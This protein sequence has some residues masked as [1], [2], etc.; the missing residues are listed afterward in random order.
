MRRFNKKAKA[1]FVASS[2]MATSLIGGV[3]T[4]LVDVFANTQTDSSYV[5][6][7]SPLD[8]VELSSSDNTHLGVSVQDNAKTESGK[9]LVLDYTPGH[10]GPIS[11]TIPMTIEKTADDFEGL[12]MW[13]DVPETADEYSFTMYVVKNPAIW[14]DMQMASPLT[15]IS[16]DGTITEK[17]SVWKRQ[18]LNGFTG[19]VM[20]P[21]MTYS[22]PAPVAGQMY[23]I[24][25]MMETEAAENASRTEAMEMTI[26]SFGYYNDTTSFLFE[27][28]G[29]EAMAKQTVKE[30]DGYIKD[31]DELKPRNDKQKKLR[32]EMLVHF[33]NLKENFATLSEA[34]AVETAKG[35]YD[36][37]YAR[38]EEYLYGDIRQTEFIMSFAMMADTHFTTSWIN[39]NF[40]NA[41]NDAKTLDPDLSAAFILGD[42]SNEGVS[43][44]DDKYTDLDNY[45]D[46]LDSYVYQNSK[47]EKIP[48]INVMGNHDVRGPSTENY[49]SGAYA[50][51]VEMYLQREPLAKAAN[52]IQF[53]TWINGYHFV[54]LNTDEYHSDYCILSAETID[55]LDETL[56]ENE[57]GKPIFVMMHQNV[58]HVQTKSD[59]KM[60]F[61]EVIARHPTAIVSSGHAHAE[62]GVGKIVQEGDGVYVNQPAMVKAATQYYFAEVYEGGVIFRAREAATKSWVISSDVTVSNDDRSSNQL[63]S[64]DTFDS[65][66][67]TTT[68][69]T[70]SIVKADNVSGKAL[71]LVG[72]TA[73]ENVSVPVYAMGNIDNYAGYGVYI[74][75]ETAVQLAVDGVGLKANATYYNVVNGTL[76]EKTTGAN[77]EIEANG[78]VVLP[79]E[80]FDGD[81]APSK[82][83]TL[84][85]SVGDTQTVYLDKVCYYF[86]ANDFTAANSTLSYV[87]YNEDG[88]VVASGTA[89]FGSNLNVPE[90]PAKAATQ[91]ET[92]TFVGWDMDGDKVVDELPETLKGNFSATAV[93]TSTARQYTYTFLAADGVEVLETATVD[94]GTAITAPTVDKL[95]GWDLDEDGAIESLP[96]TLTEGFAAVAIIGEPAYEN[97]EI[98]F[99]PSLLSSIEI[100]TFS[101][102]SAVN[103]CTVNT[104]PVANANAPS[105][106]VVQY[107]YNY[108]DGTK[109]QNG[110]NYIDMQMPYL[111]DVTN[112]QGYAIWVEV[113]ATTEGYI[114]GLKFNGDNRLSGTF[115]NGWTLIDAQ[116]NQT[117][118]NATWAGASD[119]PRIGTGFTG[120]VIADK[121]IYAG[122]VIAPNAEGKIRFQIAETGRTTP[123]T[124]SIGQVLM[125]SDKAAII[126]ELSDVNREK[127]LEYS[128]NDGNGHIY[129]AGQ[130]PAGENDTTAI[131]VPE[132]PVHSNP[133]V[134]FAGW[135]TNQDGYPDALPENGLITKDLNA[136]AIFYHVDA[137]TTIDD[138]TGARWSKENTGGTFTAVEHADSPSG[139]AMK[140]TLS[141]ASDTV[142]Y[143]KLSL[144]IDKQPTGFAV[145]MDSSSMN[146]FDMRLWKNWVNKSHIN[147]DG[148]YIYFYGDNGSLYTE[149]A[150]RDLAVPA[151][152]KGWVIIPM[153]AFRDN[154][155]LYNGDYFR[156]GFPFNDGGN[157]NLSGDVYFG[158]AVRFNCTV[159]MFLKQ[160]DKQVY[161]FK[162]Y[163]GSFIKTVLMEDGDTFSAPADPTRTDWT[164][165]GWDI[166]GD[167]KEDTLPTTIGRSFV[168]TAV[169]T[170]TFT[171]KFVD[172]QNNVILEKTAEY[173]TLIL[174]PFRYLENDPYY[175]YTVDYGTWEAGMLLTQDYT[176]VVTSERTAK[177]FTYT[178]M[179]GTEIV[180][181]GKLTYGETITLP[182]APT[183]D[184]DAQY[185]YT[186]KGWTGYTD[187]MT[188]AGDV[189]FTAEYTT[190]TN[191]YDVVF[192]DEDGT[193]V[194]SS[195]EVEYGA[196]ITLP[197]EPTKAGYTFKGWT[198][199]TDGMTV[200]QDVSFTAIFEENEPDQDSSS[201]SSSGDSSS[202]SSEDSSDSSVDS[203]DNSSD[204]SSSNGGQGGANAWGCNGCG[205]NL[206]GSMTMVALF[207]MIGAWIAIR[208]AKKGRKE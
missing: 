62:F 3:A 20:M 68:N 18:Q 163:D 134:F 99:D 94:Y 75:S 52:S 160:I 9:G 190:T 23:Q 113:A 135:D 166:D 63:F 144:P 45:Y 194:L 92:F 207:A 187:G 48:I 73:T 61:Q 47:G 143:A 114:G 110:A 88:T 108:T 72:A 169:Y 172:E 22:D 123:Y 51:A 101:Y 159:E 137:F 199:Y 189:T 155:T 195:E 176:F 69:V 140:F 81:C 84:T 196:T 41:L 97:A 50:P 115:A 124:M 180:A 185:T 109:T 128:F 203:S 53:D 7:Y 158:E 179:N 154:E 1:L 24:I 32:N 173:N 184:A 70:A 177:E 60:T 98:V 26:G 197:S 25:I 82:T 106:K 198:G 38:M 55:W 15:L 2:V 42:L 193:T 200:T 152:F 8:V 202:D 27:K 10:S 112:F 4:T 174:P 181:S 206:G 120:W 147:E 162:D 11:V 146:A 182:S 44:V 30:I 74:E 178:F 46:W 86:N 165:V 14:Q 153:T 102:N 56:A 141:K 121:S 171:Y 79:K 71:K 21:A 89:A 28:A 65:S 208:F 139:K 205:G 192:Y 126:A 122:D 54:F 57:D 43:L 132:D 188:I 131:I 49:P 35:L 36:D 164:F 78:W 93:Y 107:T 67:L 111:G 133:D 104:L 183:K 6:L 5:E 31:V 95:F 76:T 170:R 168:A 34:D 204:N 17:L 157:S 156:F 39:T 29:V 66:T 129:K 191:K 116:G 118:Q 58:E 186:F 77:G 150:W 59:A 105:G 37:Y 91:K 151:N 100:R 127:A 125:Y 130:I 138:G 80:A 149:G 19:W 201:G 103:L 96:E 142:A 12:A 85:V 90:N 87:Y 161:G 13:V 64:A 136:V 83:T 175:T 33:T 167:G 117:Q 145:W 16:E 40:L 119:F 148:D